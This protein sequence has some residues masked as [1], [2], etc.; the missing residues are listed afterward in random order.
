[1]E[2][3]YTLNN[4]NLS[5]RRTNTTRT[6]KTYIQVNKINNQVFSDYTTFLKSKFSLEIDE[7]N[8][9]LPNN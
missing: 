2:P 4:I 9:Q 3:L 6:N 7:E 8:K 5:K 1:M